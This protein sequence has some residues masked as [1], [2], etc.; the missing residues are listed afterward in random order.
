MTESKIYSAEKRIFQDNELILLPT[1]YNLTFRCQL[2]SSMQPLT[3]RELGLELIQNGIPVVPRDEGTSLIGPIFSPLDYE[4]LMD[5]LNRYSL[6]AICGYH[7][8]NNDFP[9]C[10]N[11]R[12]SLISL[13]SPAI[14]ST[15]RVN[16]YLNWSEYAFKYAFMLDEN[17]N[18]EGSKGSKLSLVP[19]EEVLS[20]LPSD[21][22]INGSIIMKKN[23]DFYQAVMT[24]WQIDRMIDFYCLYTKVDVNG[25]SG[26]INDPEAIFSMN[27]YFNKLSQFADEH[28]ILT[29]ENT[30]ESII[31]YPQKIRQVRA[32]RDW[33]LNSK[34][35]FTT[36]IVVLG[37]RMERRLH[38]TTTGFC[39]IV[40]PQVEVD[41]LGVT[42]QI[43]KKN[44]RVFN[45]NM[46]NRDLH[47]SI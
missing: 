44:G 14:V 7:P 9:I 39:P 25:S 11:E 45:H 38:I 15:Y 19:L 46:G 22:G 35:P 21:D 28:E 47:L 24:N 27:N 16:D 26:F 23:Q 37:P 34:N 5:V 43:A 12:G 13:G 41:K 30:G 6:S 36:K 1:P 3:I 29:G 42:E 10:F 40:E 33:V 17:G 32:I 31:L 18:Y 8:K 20:I 4:R 2:P